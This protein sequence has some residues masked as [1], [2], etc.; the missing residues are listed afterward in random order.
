MRNSC[1]NVQYLLLQS[2][3]SCHIACGAA[4]VLPIVTIYTY[5]NSVIS[6]SYRRLIYGYTSGSN[7]AFQAFSILS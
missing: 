7:P 5:Y 4:A 6:N 1:L 2:T 3:C